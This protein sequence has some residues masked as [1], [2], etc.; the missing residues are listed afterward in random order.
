MAIDSDL[1]AF[2]TAVWSVV[3]FYLGF[4]SAKALND[5]TSAKTACDA[6][7]WC[8]LLIC[9]SQ[10]FWSIGSAIR[11]WIYFKFNRPVQDSFGVMMCVTLIAHIWGSI[12]YFKSHGDCHEFYITTYP[13]LWLVLKIAVFV[14]IGSILFAIAIPFVLPIL[15]VIL[16]IIYAYICVACDACWRCFTSAPEPVIMPVRTNPYVRSTRTQSASINSPADSAPITS[17]ADLRHFGNS[18][19]DPDVEMA[20][21][22]VVAEA[23]AVVRET[24]TATAAS[25]D[26]ATATTT[27]SSP[28]V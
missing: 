16:V 19:P 25:T 1:A 24:T 13:E 20:D 14:Y 28:A 15:M 4:R 23:N 8:V 5:S 17:P 12:A 7:W 6:I 26:T 10:W 3:Y 11:L 27:A 2:F 22:D 9:I 21:Y 18:N